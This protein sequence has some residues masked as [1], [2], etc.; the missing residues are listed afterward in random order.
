VASI[1]QWR[2]YGWSQGAVADL[3]RPW[4]RRLDGMRR[5]LARSAP[6]A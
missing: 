3:V 6:G 2:R 1:A 4:Q 5:Y